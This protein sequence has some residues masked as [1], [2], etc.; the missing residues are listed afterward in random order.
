MKA[1]SHKKIWITSGDIDGVGLEVALKA[2]KS[3]GPKR[4]TQF[5][6]FA[7]KK[8]FQKLRKQVRDFPF[9]VLEFHSLI[10]ATSASLNFRHLYVIFDGRAPIE[11]VRDS[12]QGC[13]KNPHQN[14][15]V[16]GPL[17]KSGI[18]RAG[19]KEIGHT[20]MLK[21]LCKSKFLFQAYLG[22]RMNVML[23]TDHISLEKVPSFCKDKKRWSA[24]LN[25]AQVLMAR[26]K[27]KGQLAILALDPHSGE[28]GIIGNQDQSFEKWMNASKFKSFNYSTLSFSCN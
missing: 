2:L 12:A 14:A 9:E 1:Q 17:S 25:E 18:L 28:G 6:L 27:L 10:E 24:A 4:G 20:E 22:S 7:D 21:T 16:T 5:F 13:L 19:Y 23:L 11:W 3:I 15:L 8:A 26:L